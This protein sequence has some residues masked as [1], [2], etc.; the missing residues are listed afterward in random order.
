M[1]EKLRGSS[2]GGPPFVL[3]IL[4]DNAAFAEEGTPHGEIARILY[5]LAQRLE[6]NPYDSGPWRLMDSNGNTVGEARF[7]SR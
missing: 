6:R 3:K 7:L 4:T 1:R 2:R 5:R